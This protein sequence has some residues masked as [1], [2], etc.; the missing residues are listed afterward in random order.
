MLLL[1]QKKLRLFAKL[2]VAFLQEIWLHVGEY[3]DFN[4]G[5]MFI[6]ILNDREVN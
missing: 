1:A 5:G 6:E 3:W 2:R 4:I